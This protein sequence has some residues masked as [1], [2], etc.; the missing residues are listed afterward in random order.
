MTCILRETYKEPF[1]EG[2]SVPV[3]ES[4]ALYIKMCAA[5]LRE[6]VQCSFQNYGL[7]EI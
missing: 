2:E 4:K 7:L 3:R 6:S 5:G 1:G